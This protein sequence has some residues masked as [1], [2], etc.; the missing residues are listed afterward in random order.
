MQIRRRAALRQIWTL[1]VMVVRAMQ[2]AAST[3]GPGRTSGRSCSIT[4]PQTISQHYVMVSRLFVLHSQHARTHTMC[5]TNRTALWSLL[6]R[7]V[8]PVIAAAAV[9]ANAWS[10]HF[11]SAASDV[12]KTTT[13]DTA[14]LAVSH[15]GSST[16]AR[17]GQPLGRLQTSMPLQYVSPQAHHTLA[18]HYAMGTWDTHLQRCEHKGRC[19][20]AMDTQCCTSS[21]LQH[22]LTWQSDIQH[23][24]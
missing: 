2:D 18:I 22:L 21:R 12:S 23:S 13:D 9:L 19:L 4:V 10:D 14:S 1:L 5:S 7:Q 20:N 11:A 24:L 8:G 6:L 15:Q 17:S 16:S 3:I